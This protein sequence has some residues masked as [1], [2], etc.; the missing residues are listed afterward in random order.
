MSRFSFPFY[1]SPHECLTNKALMSFTFYDI[2]LIHPMS[3]LLT[4]HSCHSP[5]TSF[6]ALSSEC[7]IRHSRPPCILKHLSPR[8]SS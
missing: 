8:T 4:R 5:S 3:A 1:D 7:L 6:P 2:L